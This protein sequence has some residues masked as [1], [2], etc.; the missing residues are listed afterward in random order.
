M[1]KGR[2]DRRLR[3]AVCGFLLIA[4]ALLPSNA[5]SGPDR[6]ASGKGHEKGNEPVLQ[7]AEPGGGWHPVRGQ[8]AD[9]LDRLLRTAVPADFNIAYECNDR[10]K[11]MEQYDYRLKLP[12]DSRELL[13]TVKC[14]ISHADGDNRLY[15]AADHAHVQA[16]FGMLRLDGPADRRF[17]RLDEGNVMFEGEFDVTGEGKKDALRLRD[18]GK[19]AARRRAFSP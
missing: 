4:I 7:L 14:G 3:I 13:Y 5:A 6:I 11:S 2:I 16:I 10:F 8:A 18:N 15:L 1:E 12:G 9:E 19:A 17:Y